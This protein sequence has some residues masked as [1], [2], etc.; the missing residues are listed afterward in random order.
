MYRYRL[1]P[2]T[3][4]YTLVPSVLIQGA[5]QERLCS[6]IAVRLLSPKR[7]TSSICAGNIFVR[8]SWK[9]EHPNSASVTCDL[10]HVILEG[11]WWL[12]AVKAGLCYEH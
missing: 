1:S 7:V 10:F 6:M 2:E 12:Q 8:V 9:A 11:T 3:F 5:A 4:G